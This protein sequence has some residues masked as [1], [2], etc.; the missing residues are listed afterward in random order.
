M[1]FIDLKNPRQ[2]RLLQSLAK[3]LALLSALLLLLRIAG[4]SLYDYTD[5]SLEKV[6]SATLVVV[7]TGGKGRISTALNTYASG[8]GQA[9]FVAGAG[10]KTTREALIRE[11]MSA[12]AAAQLSEERRQGIIVETQSRNT[13]ENAYAVARFLRASP[14]I[15]D[16]ILITS[17]YHMRRSL[18]IFDN[19]LGKTVTIHPQTAKDSTYGRETW[20]DSFTGFTITLQECGKLLLAR[21]FL[22]LLEIF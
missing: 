5:P 3:G 18:L 13:I 11:N 16:V 2:A 15:T 1:Q 17:A 12:E 4:D 22:P 9:L 10:A 7:L 8:R 21:V 6:G 19:A 20:W 14:E